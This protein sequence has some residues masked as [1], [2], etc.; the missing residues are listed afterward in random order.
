MLRYVTSTITV[1]ALAVTVSVFAQEAAPAPAA[2]EQAPKPTLTGCVVQAKT[3]DGGTAYL[4]SKAQGGSAT[5]YVLAGSQSDWPANVNKTIEVTGAVR[6]PSAP[7][8]GD[9]AANP[10][11]LRPPMVEVESVKVVAETCK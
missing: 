8:E 9:A 7:A 6:E 1:A 10:K 2:K 5:V 3:T 4:L 11:V